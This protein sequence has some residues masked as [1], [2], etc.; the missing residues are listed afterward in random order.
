[1]S[2]KIL[3]LLLACLLSSYAV[4]AAEQR[5]VQNPISDVIEIARTTLLTIN[6]IISEV[7]NTARFEVN[8]II[9]SLDSTR[10]IIVQITGEIIDKEFRVLNHYI[11]VIK[12]KTSHAGTVLLQCVEDTEGEAG[13]VRKDFIDETLGCVDAA[14]STYLNETFDV[15]D[16]LQ[17][18]NEEFRGEEERL[19]NC[20]D[21]LI[22]I[23]CIKDIVFDVTK[24]ALKIPTMIREE[25]A[26][27]ISDFRKVEKEL[28]ECTKTT[29]SNLQ[30]RIGE[31][32]DDFAECVNEE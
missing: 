19:K 11:D 16:G 30:K 21:K 2:R 17:E 25:T 5:P 6:S 27:F 14:I 22:P 1:M 9:H 7:I 13:K 3:S 28:F 24:T 32:F 4:S 23:D 31:V 8:E 26:K 15:I 18:L 29:T 12:N 20:E 10:R